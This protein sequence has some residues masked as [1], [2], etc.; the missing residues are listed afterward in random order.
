MQARPIPIVEVFVPAKTEHKVEVQPFALST[1]LRG[2]KSKQEMRDKIR[3]QRGKER[4]RMNFK[5][6][7]MPISDEPVSYYLLCFFCLIC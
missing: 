7:P 4:E 5:A 3:K 6:Q 2:V 1:E